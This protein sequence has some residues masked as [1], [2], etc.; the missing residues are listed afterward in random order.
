MELAQKCPSGLCPICLNDFSMKEASVRTHCDH[1]I[2]RPCF[3][4]YIRFSKEEIQRELSEW[5]SDLRDKVNRELHC[6]MCREPLREDDLSELDEDEL[7]KS[8]N[9]FESNSNLSPNG[10][11][12]FDWDW[13]TWKEIQQKW[14]VIYQKQLEKGGIIDVN[15]ERNRFLVTDETVLDSTSSSLSA[16]EMMPPAATRGEAEREEWNGRDEMRNS[17]EHPYSRHNRHP[18]AIE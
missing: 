18:K 1:Y 3:V 9:L 7:Q 6:P 5:P 10:T 16:S 8:R 17:S 14:E 2:H 15:E 13:R 4:R 11:D 12:A